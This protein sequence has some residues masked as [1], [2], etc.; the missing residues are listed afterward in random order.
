MN[1]SKIINP[2]DAKNLV[3]QAVE[4]GPKYDLAKDKMSKAFRTGVK[5]MAIS[6]SGLYAYYAIPAETRAKI[7]KI[8]EQPALPTEQQ[9]PKTK[10]IYRREDG[11]LVG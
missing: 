6:L 7:E 10:P 11:P 9:R 1:A 4:A 5:G 3:M 2:A 8:M